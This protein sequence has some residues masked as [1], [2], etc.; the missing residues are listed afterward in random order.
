MAHRRSPGGRHAPSE[1]SLGERRR[2]R[3]PVCAGHPGR[4]RRRVHDRPD[5]GRRGRLRR[6]G[7]RAQRTEDPAHRAW[8]V[9][10]LLGHVEQ[11]A[12]WRRSPPSRLAAG[13]PR[14]P[15][16]GGRG[17]RPAG[18]P[19]RPRRPP[20]RTTRP[21]HAASPSR[22]HAP[23]ARRPPGRRPP[24]VGFAPERHPQATVAERGGGDRA[25]AQRVGQDQGPTIRADAHQQLVAVP[26]DLEVVAVGER[27][28]DARARSPR[29]AS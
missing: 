19:A 29:P 4:H 11:R 5:R 8:V 21:S 27:Q 6:V 17:P 23:A 26:A 22:P 24:G 9:D 25:A 13:A 3:T 12:A 18:R 28:V 14:R 10:Q 20:P 16:G 2:L 15:G 7:H 1:R